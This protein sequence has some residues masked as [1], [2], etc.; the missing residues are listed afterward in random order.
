VSAADCHTHC[1][2]CFASLLACVLCMPLV[3]PTAA[4]PRDAGWLDRHIVYSH[5]WHA[6]MAPG[7]LSLP[8]ATSRQQHTGSTQ[9]TSHASMQSHTCKHT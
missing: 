6:C 1:C 9:Q 4:A 3:A 2:F 5:G 7:A 8:G